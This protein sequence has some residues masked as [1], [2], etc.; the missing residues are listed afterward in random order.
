MQDK[1]L[2]FEASPEVRSSDKQVH[3]RNHYE[4]RFNGNVTELC[5]T[6]WEIA[7]REKYRDESPPVRW[8]EI[9]DRDWRMKDIEDL[10]PGS[11]SSILFHLNPGPCPRLIR[12]SRLLTADRGRYS[13]RSITPRTINAM[14]GYGRNWIKHERSAVNSISIK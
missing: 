14:P 9:M 13:I 6:V 8:G 4:R 10:H 2:P 11:V 3:P 7:S 5:K 12:E 1:D